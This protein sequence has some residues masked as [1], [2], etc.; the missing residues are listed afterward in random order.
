MRPSVKMWK[1]LL[2]DNNSTE[3]SID[4]EN[5]KSLRL[6]SQKTKSLPFSLS[7]IGSLYLPQRIKRRNKSGTCR[8]K[9]NQG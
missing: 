3:H 2:L 6:P 1:M 9:R 5:K 4:A 7:S 8:T